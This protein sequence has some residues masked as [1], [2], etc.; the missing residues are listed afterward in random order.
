MNA[1]TSAPPIAGWRLILYH[2][3]HDVAQRGINGLSLGSIYAL[4]GVG[5]TLVYGILKL[6]NFA[7]GDFLTFGAYMAYIV[8]VTW[9]GPLVLGII[10][11]VI[12]TAALGV[13]LEKGMFAPMRRKGAGVLQL[14][15]MTLALGFVIRYAVQFVWSTELRQLDVNRSAAESLPGDLRIGRI[16]LIILIVGIITLVATGLMLRL[17]TL[18]KQMRALSDNIDLAETSGINTSR[19]ILYT[20]IFAAGLAGLAGVFYGAST[21]LQ[22]EMGFELL[23]PIFAAVVLGGIGNAFGALTAGLVLGVVIEWSTLFLLSGL[24]FV[25]G[26]GILIIVLI[27]RPEGIF[28]RARTV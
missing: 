21:Q 4:A 13:A 28:G 23:L 8:N 19:V 12:A 15:L 11:A 22:P 18:G 9:G 27:I 3:A 14:L 17:T 26:F 5:L 20:W 6:V 16:S 10:F 24:K 2:G 7:H 1:T 25:V